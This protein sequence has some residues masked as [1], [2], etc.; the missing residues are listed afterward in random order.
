[1]HAFSIVCVV[2]F[3]ALLL[4]P[5]GANAQSQAD[6]ILIH[7]KIWTENPKQPEAEAV[8]IKGSR[9]MAVGDSATIFKLSG[10]N[11]KVIELHGRRV[12]PGFNDAH[13]HF[14]MGGDGLASV[15]LHETSSAEEFRKAIASFARRQPQ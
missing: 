7:G 3:V 8:A 6:L 11:T 12:V 14:Y 4:T 5:G 13:V 2:V 1:M 15:Q 10:P 9:I